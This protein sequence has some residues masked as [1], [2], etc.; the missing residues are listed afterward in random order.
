VWFEVEGLGISNEGLV[1]GFYFW[2]GSRDG[3]GDLA[4]AEGAWICEDISVVIPRAGE[5]GDGRRCSRHT[6]VAPA[7][8]R[9]APGLGF[10][11]SGLRFGT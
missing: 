9:F 10:R 6:L 5:E 1:S 2:D 7:R 8:I 11:I 4:E 3:G